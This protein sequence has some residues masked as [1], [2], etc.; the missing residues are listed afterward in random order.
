M[1]AA[2][3][4]V[5]LAAFAVVIGVLVL[6]QG[7]SDSP[8]LVEAT[9]SGDSSDGG[10]GSGDNGSTAD[11][12]AAAD[13]GSSDDGTAADGSGDDGATSDDSTADDGTSADDGGEDELTDPEDPPPATGDDGDS[14]VP[15]ILHPAAEVRVLVANGT[16]VA[17]AAGRADDALEAAKGYGGPEPTNTTAPAEA[18]II[19]YEPGYELDARQ[20]AKILNAAPTAVAPMPAE[21][22]VDDLA[23][24][25]VLVVIGPDYDGLS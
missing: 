7:F 3:R 22:P 16:T 17:G 13:G 6:G 10:A 23:E 18:T 14:D 12:A 21:P 1:N 8:T 24:A 9:S 4:G 15:D 19:Y 5:I 25:H 11:D 2:A 20:I